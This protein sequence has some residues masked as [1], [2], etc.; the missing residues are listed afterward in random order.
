[1]RTPV[2]AFQ[3]LTFDLLFCNTWNRQSGEE[4]LLSWQWS[5][6]MILSTEAANIKFVHDTIRQGFL[7]AG[8]QNEKDIITMSIDRRDG[9]ASLDSDAI[10][11]AIRNTDM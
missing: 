11:C 7:H 5:M 2:T 1:L 9:I 10:F 8:L 3:K 6:K 4:F